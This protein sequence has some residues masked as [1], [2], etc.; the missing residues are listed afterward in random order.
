MILARTIQWFYR[1]E[2]SGV[3]A[4]VKAKYFEILEALRSKAVAW[5][6]ALANRK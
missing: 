6:Q 1:L 5:Q 3:N 2:E 4:F